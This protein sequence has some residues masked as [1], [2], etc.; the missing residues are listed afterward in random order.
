MFS[1]KIEYTP[2]AYHI[3]VRDSYY[4]GFRLERI[5][6]VFDRVIDSA[7]DTTRAYKYIL[8]TNNNNNKDPLHLEAIRRV[9][10]ACNIT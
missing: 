3:T 1:F 6:F 4:F 5:I 9:Y 10:Y 7:L 8:N 2:A